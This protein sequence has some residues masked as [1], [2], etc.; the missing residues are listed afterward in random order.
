MTDTL[1]VDAGAADEAAGRLEAVAADGLVT[2]S[3]AGATNVAAVG[4]GVDLASAF[5]ALLG[6][7][8]G[9]IDAKAQNLRQIAAA[10]IAADAAIAGG[11]Q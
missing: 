10:L 1:V 7:F 9:V 3:P 11:I 5:N 4:R 8:D 2:V 6:E